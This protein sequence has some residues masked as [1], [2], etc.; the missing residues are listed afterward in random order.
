MSLKSKNKN[1]LVVIGTHGTSG[2]EELFIGSTAMRIISMCV[3]VLTI[4][5]SVSSHRDLTI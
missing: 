3:V 2:F 4:R 5:D 1:A